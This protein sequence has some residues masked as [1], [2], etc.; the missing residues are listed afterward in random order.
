MKPIELRAIIVDD[1]APSRELL[2]E[3][4]AAH[5]NV[6]VIGEANSVA[7]AAALC[8][9]LRPNL[10]FL[11]VQM[12]DGDG[13]SLL[14]KLDPLPAVIFVTAFDE[15]AVRAFEVNAVDY[16]SKPV[17]PDRLAHALQ[18]IIR[19]PRPTH[20]AVLLE[21][22]RIFLHSDAR[23][24]VVYVTEISGIEAQENYSL[25]H[26]MDGT[27]TLIRRS[28]SEWEKLLPKQCF[29]R[30][31]RSLIVNLQ[32]VKKVVMEARDEIGVELPGFSVPIRLGRRAALRLR[33]ALRQPNLL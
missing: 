28:M 17:R 6:Q 7:T 1:E 32:A 26:L 18:R 30:T 24:R 10:I 31:H 5:P 3:L 8:A 16:L 2:Q 29:L 4:L 23:L 11:D 33:R 22:D 21:D 25:V 15:F 13:F 19:E 9:D 12:P 27:S 20:S 14:P